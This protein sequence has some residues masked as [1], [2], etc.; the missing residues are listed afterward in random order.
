VRPRSF[1]GILIG[2]ALFAA[3]GTPTPKECNCSKFKNGHFIYKAQS[4]FTYTIE[5]NDSIQL[6]TDVKTGDYTKLRIKWRDSC[7]YE[8]L[9]METTIATSDS[10]KNVRKTIPFRIRIV[11]TAKDYYTFRG[12]REMG[13]I[14]TDTIWVDKNK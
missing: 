13:K 11:S 3:C 5:R 9:M 6:E 2:V 10:M 8:V 1:T 4:G 7:N 14:V 12:Q